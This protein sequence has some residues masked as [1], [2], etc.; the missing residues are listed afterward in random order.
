MH[1]LQRNIL[2]A[3]LI[4]LCMTGCSF[5]ESSGDEPSSNGNDDDSE[6]E[7]SDDDDNND[8]VTCVPDCEGKECGDDGCGGSCGKCSEDDACSNEG[9]CKPKPICAEYPEC[10]IDMDC[11]SGEF[12]LFAK[13]DDKI[14]GTCSP[15]CKSNTD[16]YNHWVCN[17]IAG[18]CFPEDTPFCNTQ[19]DC[20]DDRFCLL[21]VCYLK[22]T[23][24]SNNFICGLFYDGNICQPSPR[25]QFY[26]EGEG[27][28]PRGIWEKAMDDFTTRIEDDQLLEELGKITRGEIACPQNEQHVT[29]SPNF[30]CKAETLL[31]DIFGAPCT[32]DA[33]C[34]GSFCFDPL[35]V[36]LSMCLAHDQTLECQTATIDCRTVDP[37]FYPEGAACLVQ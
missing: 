6:P 37:I 28:L 29:I 31:C 17:H 34:P 3:V 18:I 1:N 36:C 10:L 9:K 16:C 2:W 24:S 14:C 8:S 25:T 35:G 19:A 23:C 33:D 21:G 4:I 13:P 26:P 5:V 30:V 32:T 22:P 11:E 15:Q 7:D 27:Y 20:A 12:C